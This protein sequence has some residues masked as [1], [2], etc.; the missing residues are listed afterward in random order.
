MEMDAAGVVE[1]RA[2]KP[3]EAGAVH[4]IVQMT[5]VKTAAII[6]LS[7]NDIYFNDLQFGISL[8]SFNRITCRPK[9]VFLMLY[10][11]DLFVQSLHYRL[12]M[13]LKPAGSGRNLHAMISRTVTHLKLYKTL[14]T[15]AHEMPSGNQGNE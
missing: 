4:N 8:D 6:I 14:P 5:L 11:Y 3:E 10:L 7:G 15:S 2:P 13:H 9:I 12:S 1:T